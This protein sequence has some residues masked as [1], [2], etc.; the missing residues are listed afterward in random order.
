MNDRRRTVDDSVR[1]AGE[2]LAACASHIREGR[3]LSDWTPHQ[4]EALL[5]AC[6]HHPHGEEIERKKAENLT[7][8]LFRRS[9]LRPAQPVGDAGVVPER[10]HA[11]LP[12]LVRLGS[13][14][15]L[16]RSLDP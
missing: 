4:R 15:Y 7:W 5:A 13:G 3:A 16:L 1:F 14:R 11:D 9:S 8:H 2:V 6:F 12:G 10:L